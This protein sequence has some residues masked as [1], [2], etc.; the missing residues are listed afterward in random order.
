MPGGATQAVPFG[1]TY[2]SVVLMLARQSVPGGCKK[3]WLSGR[4]A[5][6]L[7]YPELDCVM[8]SLD[9]EVRSLTDGKVYRAPVSA[10]P[11]ANSRDG[12]EIVSGEEMATPESTISITFDYP[13]KKSAEFTF[14][15]N[16]GFT[17]RDL[18][19]AIYDGYQRMYSAEPD[20]GTVPGM[21]N[22]ARSTGPYGIY[23]HYLED[24]IIGGIYEVQPG[25][26]QL[27]INS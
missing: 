4:L 27:D 5:E 12:I 1:T 10:Y 15:Q 9:I 18:Y 17:R 14:T 19:R 24:L 8:N 20:P 11:K 25:F 3:E 16:G 7:V 22:R 13:L 6:R 23:G 2:N 26:F 21:A